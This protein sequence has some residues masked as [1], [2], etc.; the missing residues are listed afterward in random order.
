[1]RSLVGIGVS[2]GVVSLLACS[3]SPTAGTEPECAPGFAEACT[4]PGGEEGTQA[5]GPG[6]KLEAC[7]CSGGGGANRDPT[8]EADYLIDFG[9]LVV[10]QRAVA[11]LPLRNAGTTPVQFKAEPVGAPFAAET[12]GL[13][14][15]QPGESGELRWA[16]RPGRAGKF[17]VVAEV[18]S[19]EGP[20]TVRLAGEGFEPAVACTPAQ[21]DF[22]GQ[23]IGLQVVREVV[24]VN[25]A[26]HPWSLAAGPAEGED[27]DSFFVEP[28]EPGPVAP[29]GSWTLGVG[30]AIGRG[31]VLTAALPLASHT[32]RRAGTIPLMATGLSHGL[33]CWPMVVDFGFVQPGTSVRRQ[34]VCNND[35]SVPVR[36]TAL[37]LDD[38]STFGIRAVL[39]IE[40][41]AR[42]EDEPGE[43]AIDLL[44][45]PR[46]EDLGSR[47]NATLT[48]SSDAPATPR[49]LAQLTGFGGGPVIACSPTSL[50]FGIVAAALPAT[51]SVVCSNVGVDDPTRTDDLLVVTDLMTSDPAQFVA[52]PREGQ[53]PLY[54]GIGDTFT[55]D[56]TYAPVG[57]GVDDGFVYLPS[58]AVNAGQEAPYAVS[59]TGT[60]RDLPPCEIDLLPGNLWFGSID[61]GSA[62]TLEFAV[63]NNRLDAE[64]LLFD[65]RLAETCSAAFSLPGGE[66]HLEV[67]PPGGEVRFPVRF[68]PTATRDQPYTCDVLFEAPRVG[69]E[70]VVVPAVGYSIE[71]CVSVEPEAIDFGNNKVGCASSGREVRVFNRCS[72]SRALANVAIGAGPSGEFAIR[73]VPPSGTAISPGL[74]TAITLAYRPG[75]MGVDTGSVLISFDGE[76]QPRLVTLRG[77]GST[78]ATQLDEFMVN[79]RPKVD[80][81]F[82]IDN[83]SGM[84]MAQAALAANLLPFHSFAQAQE[85]D[86]QIGVTTT[87]LVP[88][89]NA[90]NPCPGGA[91]GG[92]SGRL[93][94][95]NNSRPRILTP[96]TPN[97]EAVWAANVSVGTCHWD[98]QPLEAAYRALMPPVI[99]SCDDPRFPEHNDGN[100]GFLRPDAHL[101]IVAVTNE[102]DQSPMSANLYL[103]AFWALKPTWV[104]P[105]VRFDA[106]TG[107][108]ITGCNAGGNPVPAGD[109]LV[110]MSEQ[111]EGGAFVSICTSNWEQQLRGLSASVFGFPRCFPLQN[112]PEDT[113]GNGTI[114]PAEGEIQVKMNG[115]VTPAVG[116]QGQPIWE[117]RANRNALCFQALAVP[118]PG[119]AIEVGYRNACLAW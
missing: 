48:L 101:S 26:A 50:D 117:Y 12:A 41:P 29:G 97:R 114:S 54:A 99:D 105:L 68:A 8:G 58:N 87:G 27:G 10:E 88:V 107:D 1:M 16:F 79:D 30:A 6:R 92:E 89:T 73:S 69:S 112:Q 3:T 60:G 98:E 14:L 91:A 90:S 67:V 57:D 113:N 85:I 109:K 96:N 75:D 53:A 7:D 56:V 106:I 76:A 115:H 2:I 61:A 32:G 74:F 82:V 15:L 47:R 24:C 55:V 86:F 63:R 119:T 84:E 4:C 111:T 39:P 45:H 9:A 31:G 36:I 23:D 78:D 33:S 18:T 46:P 38:A 44:F 5:C 70:H 118:E 28:Y 34:I 43:A 21:V 108:K 110:F 11:G 77:R 59:L 81:L 83:S 19:S 17:S 66:V 93:F 103:Q 72:T 22:G 100:C 62:A 104:W 65:L 102:V 95:I 52:R 116:T 80:V 64:C 49:L 94:P 25:T 40:V 13:V 51:R 42:V 35:S 71:S 20:V 37:D